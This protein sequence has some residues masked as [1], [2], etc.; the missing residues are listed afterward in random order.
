MPFNEIFKLLE[1]GVFFI[2]QF[3]TKEGG[4]ANRNYT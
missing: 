4:K 1:H 3:K 2:P